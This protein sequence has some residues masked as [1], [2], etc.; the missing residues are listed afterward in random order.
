MYKMS[1]DHGQFIEIYDFVRV[2]NN[3]KAISENFNKLVMQAVNQVINPSYKYLARLKSILDLPNDLVKDEGDKKSLISILNI[4]IDNYVITEDN[5]KKMVLLI[6]RIKA[7]VPVIIMGETGCGKTSLIKKLSQILNN[8]EELVK[9]INIHP[10]ITDEEITNKMREMNVEAKSEKY[11]GKELW[12]F[13]DEINTCLSLSLLTEIFINRT[14]NGEKLEDNIRLIGACNP[15]R[16]RKELI[17]R[18]GLTREDDED[19]QLVYKV[20][21]LPQS[22]LY[23]VF[24]FGSLQDDDEKKYIKS[25]IQKLFTEEDEEKLLDLTTEA[26]SQ[27]HIF[28]RKS[29]GNDPSIVSLREIARFKTCVE[30]FENYFIKK[31]D[32]IINTKVDVETKKVNKIK[33][34]ICSIYLCYY[35][36][37]T[38]EERRGN[39]EYTLRNKLLQI[40]NVHCEEIEED[41]K[42]D[43]FSQIR[44]QK[45]RDELREKNI[46]K[47]SDLLKIEE[48]F[49]LE[50]VEL[51]KGIGKNQL[52]K[53]NLFLLFLALVTKIPLII[54]GKPGTGK[55]LSAQLIYNSMR[56]KYSKPKNGKKSFFTKYP[57][58]NQTY[59]QGS[60][61]TTPEDIEELFKKTED[62][63]SIYKKHNKDDQLVPIYMILFDELGLADKSPTN[64]LKVLHNKL[65][66]GGKTEGTCFVGISNYSLDAAKVNRALSLSVPNLEDKFDQL[67]TTAKSI[68]ESISDDIYKDNLI[69]NILARAYNRYKY[70]LTFIKKLKVVKEYSKIKNIKGKNFKEIEGEKEF[71]KLLKKDKIIKSDFHGN[72]DFYNIIK[73]VAIDGSKLNSISDEK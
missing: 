19:D 25:I 67:K 65:E 11:K 60:E 33:S 12:V 42:G 61:T 31:N 52:L 58:I 18:C 2:E 5:Y 39:F 9:I 1:T 17:E 40:A 54:V 69:F 37:L 36:R 68:V 29:F 22:L 62:L 20:E 26:I 32:Q 46:Q 24:S 51:D 59:F 71:I 15:Y 48:D 43:L 38:N 27:C 35:I 53:E 72:R 30:F 70:Y 16:K 4:G 23:Y 7:N 50:Q 57:Q 13:F 6:Y 56:G 47:F 34:I 10:G 55:S 73:G 28:L 64:P 49:L 45:L 8:G 21:Q 44:Y 3:Q 14:F 66:Y 63:Y 41:T